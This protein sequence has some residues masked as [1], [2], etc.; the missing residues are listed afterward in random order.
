MNLLNKSKLKPLAAYL[1]APF[2]LWIGIFWDFIS[3]KISINI[4]TFTNYAVVKYFYNNI[5]QGTIPLW[6]PFVSLGR[7][8]IFIGNSGIL[9]PLQQFIFFLLPALGVNYYFTYLFYIVCYSFLGLFGFYL[10]TKEFLKDQYFAYLAYLF[11][12]FSGLSLSIF[13]QIHMMH[14]FVPSIWLFYF[15]FRFSYT[16][17][18]KHFLGITFCLMLIMVSYLPF[19]FMTLFL[20]FIVLLSALFPKVVLQFLLN[21]FLFSKKNGKLLVFCIVAIGI[22]MLPLS[23]YKISTTKGENVGPSRHCNFVS[24]EECIEKTLAPESSMSYQETCNGNLA[25]RFS[26]NELFSNINKT[27]Y[28]QDGLFFIPIFGFIS[29]ILSLITY[30]DRKLIF[31]YLLFLILFLISIALSSPVHR[32]F[33]NYIFYFKYFRNLFFFLSFLIPLFILLII[34]QL[35]ALSSYKITSNK[36]KL[37]ALF[38][39][40]VCHLLLLLIL[41]KQTNVSLLTYGTVWLSWIFFIL[42]IKKKA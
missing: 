23:L 25:L 28:M 34:Y 33:Y 42:L 36:Q 13:N 1:L 3:G 14:I 29:L 12:L 8:Y 6:D 4:D 22:S 24:Y 18:T 37:R 30:A 9:N 5:H 11:L 27:S 40:S 39:T 38:Y 31:L 7:P 41:I 2:V 35:K 15:L 21:L 32:L 16:S 20:I 17:Q 26:F 19:Y 10:F